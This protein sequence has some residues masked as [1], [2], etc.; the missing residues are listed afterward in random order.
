[1]SDVSLLVVDDDRLVLATLSQSLRQV[2]Y[3]V[4]EAGS[5][6]EALQRLEDSPVRLAI[7]DIRMPGISG[8]DLAQELQGRDIPF[9]A[10]T[11]YS[12]R[13]LVAAMVEQGALCY[14]VKPVDINQ[15]LPAVETALGRADDIL[16]LKL[17]EQH[18]STALNSDR[19]ISQAVGILMERYNLSGR[20]AF[21]R[22][23]TH[24]RSQ[25]RKLAE[26]ARELVSATD[27][28]NAL[29]PCETEK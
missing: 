23:R 20:I 18:L 3:Q 21:E 11:A 1:M 16:Q 10:L 13:E 4:V 22:L 25:R 14:L 29:N 26:V 8:I 9:I 12:D 5:G 28:V 6:E 15:L 17:N 2:G 27:A 24:A 19:T 7:L